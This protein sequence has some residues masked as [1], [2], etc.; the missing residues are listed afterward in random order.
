ML[1]DEVRT[2][3]PGELAHVLVGDI[4]KKFRLKGEVGVLPINETSV[5]AKPAVCPKE[6]RGGAQA[7]SSCR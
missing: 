4:D 7:A 6:I 3:E 5:T 1:T 2:D